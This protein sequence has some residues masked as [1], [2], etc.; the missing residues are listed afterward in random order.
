MHPRSKLLSFL[1]IGAL[2]GAG[3][4]AEL[5]ARKIPALQL[6]N[7]PLYITDP[8]IEYLLKP[9]QDG[10]RFGNR[11]HVNQWGMRST[12]MASAKSDNT[13]VRVLLF[14]DSVPFGGA[15]TDQD[16]LVTSILSQELTARLGRKTVAANISAGSWGPP[17]QLA[18]ARKFGTFQADAVV[19]LLSSH[20]ASDW[21]TFEALSSNTHPTRKPF[22]ALSEAITRYLPRYLPTALKPK[23]VQ[24]VDYQTDEART[25]QTLDSL[26]ALIQ[27]FQQ[28]RTPVVLLHH[29]ERKELDAGQ[30]KPGRDSLWARASA[31]GVL[32]ASDSGV[33]AEALARGQ[34]PYRDNIHPN[35]LGQRLLAEQIEELLTVTGALR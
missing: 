33:F 17:N 6:G 13:E 27:I 26:T 16:S 7:P 5:L 29:W 9:N 35:N 30:A 1:A 12:D 10:W 2:I 11:Y 24:V 3:G 14:G 32:F 15:Q 8:N 28:S 23:T 19:L 25:S 18:F 20:D 4:V 21:P 22:S 34:N 31:A